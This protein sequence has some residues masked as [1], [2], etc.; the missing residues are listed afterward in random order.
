MEGARTLLEMLRSSVD[1][2]HGSEL[3]AA[4]F[5][6]TD[7]GADETALNAV[8]L[9]IKSKPSVDCSTHR[10]EEESHLDHDV[11]PLGVVRHVGTVV[12]NEGNESVLIVGDGD[13]AGK[14]RRRRAGSR[15]TSGGD[16]RV[17][18]E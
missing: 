1:H 5:E 16:G 8:G 6:A 12:K 13:G 14:T 2:L 11:G 10:P 4:V 7:D 18:E 15:L 3:E 17:N 9:A